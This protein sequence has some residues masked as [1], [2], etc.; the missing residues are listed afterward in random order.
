MTSIAEL[1]H[2]RKSNTAQMLR[3][4]STCGGLIIFYYIGPL[5]T[6]RYSLT[7]FTERVSCDLA[8]L[9]SRSG[10]LQR[11]SKLAGRSATWIKQHVHS[12]A[13]NYL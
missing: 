9:P 10:I 8:R 7:A 3:A 1:Q 11:Q 5:C 13:S 6:D 12:C 2:L 4:F